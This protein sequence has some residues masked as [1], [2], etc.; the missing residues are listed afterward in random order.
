MKK[1]QWSEVSDEAISLAA[2]RALHTPKEA[3]RISPNSY[4]SSADF[5]GTLSVPSTIYV[6]DGSFKYT[7]NEDA[8]TLH[9]SEFLEIEPGDFAF[10]VIGNTSV[11]IVDVFKLP[12][13][14]WANKVRDKQE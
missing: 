3:Y 9:A 2:I 10:K 14:L 13:Q 7:M 6:L 8:Q 11:K 4:N 12:A 5:V 1:R